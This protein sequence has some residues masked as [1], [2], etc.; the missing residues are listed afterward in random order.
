[1]FVAVHNVWHDVLSLNGSI[2]MFANKNEL[3]NW[4]CMQILKETNHYTHMKKMFKEIKKNC[5]D[6]NGILIPEKILSY[7]EFIL[8]CVDEREQTDEAMAFLRE[9]AK[10]GG[11][12]NEF[13]E[14]NKKPKF[15]SHLD[16][17][18]CYHIVS[19]SVSEK[20]KKEAS[21]LYYDVDDVDLSDFDMKN[22]DNV[23]IRETAHTIRFQRAY[24][25]PEVLDLSRFGYVSMNDS[26]LGNIKELKFRDGAQVGFQA[27]N[28]YRMKNVT[29]TLPKKLDVSMCSFVNLQYCDLA[30]VEELKLGGKVLLNRATNLPEVLDFS[31]SKRKYDVVRG[32][33]YSFD[34]MKIKL[35]NKQ[36]RENFDEGGF[37]ND[38]IYEENSEPAK[39]R[40]IANMFRKFFDKT[41]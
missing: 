32:I 6:K 36:H 7:K 31:C 8:S 27:F 37:E 38:F 24:N 14:I 35:R 12:E 15:Y 19:N 5:S 13:E 4:R 34:V 28:T 3:N 22:F 16:C 2:D 11:I 33:S 18:G 26:Y 39:N 30:N 29:S 20:I 10:I 23:K 9:F 25:F 41:M 21:K 40:K 1:M 17:V